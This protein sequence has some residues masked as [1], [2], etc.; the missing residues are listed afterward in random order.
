MNALTCFIT[1][2]EPAAIESL[3]RLI[4]LYCP[5]LHIKGYA[6]NT[7]DAAAFLNKEDVDILFLDIQMQGETGFDLLKQLKEPGFHLIFVTAFDEFGIT[8]IKFSATDYLLKPVDPQELIGA[9]HK[10]ATRRR[11]QQKQMQL[12]LQ[13]HMLPGSQQKRIALADQSEIKYVLISDIVCCEADNSY[14]TFYIGDGKQTV[15]VSKPIAEYEMLLQP[16]G[17]IRVHQSWLVNT[18][19]LESYK[20]ED[21]GFL[22]M[23]NGMNIPVSRQ[24]KHLLKAL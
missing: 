16:Y 18:H 23:Q 4:E 3:S 11:I 19:K 17:F 2:D 5:S 1:D 13:T 21:G 7:A 14:T 9:I 6:T 20:R 22:R 10:V 12:L 24:R 8:A 15:M